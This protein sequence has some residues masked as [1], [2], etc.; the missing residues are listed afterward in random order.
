MDMFYRRVWEQERRYVADLTHEHADEW[1]QELA[2]QEEQC[3]Q[4]QL[5]EG[6]TDVAEMETVQTRIR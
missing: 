1:M 2:Y 6:E 4:G 3:P 5:P